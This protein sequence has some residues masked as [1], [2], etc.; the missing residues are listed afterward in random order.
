LFSDAVCISL[1]TNSKSFSK[2][3]KV[4]N[5]F[6]SNLLETPE[7][8]MVEKG[9]WGMDGGDVSRFVLKVPE[10]IQ[11]KLEIDFSEYIIIPHQANPKLLQSVEEKY[12]ITMY[13]DDAMNFG[14]TTCSALFIALAN[15]LKNNSE[16][17]D[18]LCVA[19]G[20]T[21]SYGTFILKK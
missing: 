21:E 12:G 8:L 4:E 13:K 17:K 14:N 5:V 18:Y 1:W 2:Y 7:S 9:Y 15:N 19:F 20:D 11:R 16:S 3:P 6:Y 10:L